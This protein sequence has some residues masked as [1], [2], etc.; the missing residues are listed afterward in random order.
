MLKDGKTIQIFDGFTDSIVCVK[1]KLSHTD[2]TPLIAMACLN[3]KIKVFKYTDTFMLLNEFDG[4]GDI[5]FICFH[6]NF[7]ALIAGGGDGTIWLWDV[8]SGDC[9]NVFVG[10]E[11]PATCGCFTPNNKRILTCSADNTTKIWNP[12]SN[13]E[14]EA[15]KL[16]HTFKGKEWHNSPIVSLSM[17]DSLPIFACGAENGRI[18]VGKIDTRKP[19]IKFEHGDISSPRNTSDDTEIFCSVEV[20]AFSKAEDDFSEHVLISGGSDGIVIIWNWKRG[21]ARQKLKTGEGSLTTGIF[22]GN[23]PNFLLT[24]VDGKVFL[25]DTK[26]GLLLNLSSSENN[27]PIFSV[28]ACIDKVLIGCLSKVMILVEDSIEG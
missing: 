13:A 6:N 3:G 23:S 25:L 2:K 7:D 5:E 15:T 8:N 27:E 19:L 14:Q 11:G 28:C 21:M 22:L 16:V 18:C 26:K 9:L 10:H 4:P 20:L 1:C 24:S 17:H 12:Q